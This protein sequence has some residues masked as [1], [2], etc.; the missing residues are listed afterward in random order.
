MFNFLTLDTG[1][2]FQSASGMRLLWAYLGT[3]EVLKGF[4]VL[5]RLG[6]NQLNDY[7]NESDRWPAKRTNL[8]YGN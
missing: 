3:S 4:Y 5:S 8:R 7:N 2:F 1:C 6:A